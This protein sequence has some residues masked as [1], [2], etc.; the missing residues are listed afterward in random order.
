L[1]KKEN[2]CGPV[3]RGD[4]FFP[5]KPNLCTVE[6]TVFPVYWPIFGETGLSGFVT[7]HFHLACSSP[8]PFLSYDAV[9][10]F[11]QQLTSDG[12]LFVAFFQ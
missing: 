6:K 10:G 9:C 7:P 1:R 3:S 4:H 5:E 11:T 12:L 8:L 2:R